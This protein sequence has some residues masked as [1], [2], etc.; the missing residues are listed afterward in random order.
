MTVGYAPLTFRW[1][2][3]HEGVRLYLSDSGELR[4]LVAPVPPGEIRDF[5]VRHRD[6][7]VRELRQGD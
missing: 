6:E 1:F 3:A 2:L 7:I 5:I 4:S